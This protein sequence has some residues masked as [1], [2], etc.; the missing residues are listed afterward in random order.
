[1]SSRLL[2]LFEG[3]PPVPRLLRRL[4][5]ALGSTALAL[6]C[7]AV[8]APLMGQA[9]AYLPLIAAL[10]ASVW[11]GGLGVALLAQ[12]SGAAITFLFIARP[13]P[14]RTVRDV[15]VYGLLAFLVFGTLLVFLTANL[16]WN[17]RLRQNKRDLEMIAHATHDSLWEW[18]LATNRIHRDGNV[19]RIFGGSRRDH[20][21]DV[22]S[23]RRRIHPDDAGRVWDSIR[24][25]V[26][27]G[28][29][30]WE[31]EYRLRC[32]E[33]TYIHV[34]D[35]GM[36]VRDK[37]GKAIRVIGGIAD[38]SAQKRAE[39]QLIY[40]ASHDALTGLP[41]REL[42]LDRIRGA[43]TARQ[44]EGGNTWAV[45]FLDIDRFKVVN[46]SLGHAVG[47]Q[48]LSAVASRLKQCLPIGA[49]DIAARFG[50]DEFTVMLEGI[51]HIGVAVRTAEQIQNLLS[52]PLELENHHIVITVSIGIA[53]A[54]PG[55]TPE[56]VLRHA[57]IAMYRA[58]ADGKARHA[59]YE[60]IIDTPAKDLL[61]LETDLRQSLRQQRFHLHYQPIISLQTGRIA[62]FEALLRWEHPRRGLLLPTDFLQ[63]AEEAGLAVPIGDWILREAFQCLAEWH[64]TIPAARSINMNINLSQRQFLQPLIVDQIKHALQECGVDGRFIILELTETMIIENSELAL[65]RIHQLRELGIRLAIDDFGKGY[66]SLGRL[67]EIPVSILKIDGSFTSQIEAGRPQIV[68][69]IIALAHQLALEV[70]AEGVETG[71]Q[72]VHLAKAGCATGQGFFFSPALE[73]GSIESLLQREPLWTVTAPQVRPHVKFATNSLQ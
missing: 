57:D 51:E 72:C 69:A 63:V 67:L 20:P 37:S 73:Q 24:Q 13:E 58:K 36:V 26:E 39:E 49:G 62:S 17:A 56:D 18:D 22:E 44:Q 47:D 64:R 10:A 60:P 3:P 29:I 34:S 6:G 5:V 7:C 14:L 52:M 33:G 19:R 41:N 43:V 68:D 27:T 11:Y 4:A 53:S 71:R 8:L 28:C 61:Q 48:L 32:A 38:V 2:T 46:D 9:G 50:G 15:D 65:S 54:G 12:I 42:F 31:Q 1:M 59:I 23:W 45:L 21:A 40:S 35:R 66:S 25:V 30:Q 55:D 16:R 70:T